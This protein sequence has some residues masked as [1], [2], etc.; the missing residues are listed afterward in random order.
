MSY[1][2]LV[3]SLFFSTNYK[4]PCL[5]LSFSAP[6]GNVCLQEDRNHHQLGGPPLFATR[7]PSGPRSI[8]GV[9]FFSRTPPPSACAE[10]ALFPSRGTAD[11]LSDTR[12]QP[13]LHPGCAGTETVAPGSGVAGT[14]VEKPVAGGHRSSHDSHGQE[15]SGRVM[16]EVQMLGLRAPGSSHMDKAG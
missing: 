9:P 3:I 16:N 15:Q 8:R 1:N 6:G 2:S 7:K 10:I 11:C 12:N 4:S 14:T 5:E 13:S